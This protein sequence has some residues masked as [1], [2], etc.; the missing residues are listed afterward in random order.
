ME[1]VAGTHGVRS[2]DFFHTNRY[3]FSRNSSSYKILVLCVSLLKIGL[4]ANFLA[5]FPSKAFLELYPI[6]FCLTMVT[7]P[8]LAKGLLIPIIIRDPARGTN[9][10]CL[11]VAW[12]STSVQTV[13]FSTPMLPVDS[14]N[15]GIFVTVRKKKSKKRHLSFLREDNL[16]DR[17]SGWSNSS[18]SPLPQGSHKIAS[19]MRTSALNASQISCCAQFR[20]FSLYFSLTSLS[21][22]F[23]QRKKKSCCKT[24]GA[25]NMDKLDASSNSNR[26][27]DKNNSPNMTTVFQG[28]KALWRSLSRLW[29]PKQR[30]LIASKRI[31]SYSRTLTKKK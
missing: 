13:C 1:K 31:L 10:L 8:S 28:F 25:E 21:I 15:G 11:R 19:R 23:F 27:Q 17:F 7:W 18:S 5:L 22:A 6:L 26:T 20:Q 9:Q 2:S 16:L 4:L 29:K 24:V 30:L 14:S 12:T 3:N